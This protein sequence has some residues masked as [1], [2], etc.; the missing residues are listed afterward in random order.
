[1]ERVAFPLLGFQFEKNGDYMGSE[2]KGY[3]AVGTKAAEEV[4]NYMGNMDMEMNPTNPEILLVIGGDHH[5]LLANREYP[6]SAMVAVTTNGSFGGT[7]NQNFSK[8]DIDYVIGSIKRGNYKIDNV[9]RVEAQYKNFKTCALNEVVV[10]Q[11]DEQ[12][13]RMRVYCDGKDLYGIEIIANGM[14]ASAPTGTSGYCHSADGEVMEQYRRKFE[15]VPLTDRYQAV[16]DT[17]FIILPTY[18]QFKGDEVI[19]GRRVPTK[20]RDYRTIKEG[21]EVVV[22]FNRD[23][24]NKIVPDSLKAYR[25][26]FD[27]KEGDQV[28]FRAAEEDAKYIRIL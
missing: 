28:I 3:W 7:A 20:V 6:K 16:D 22:T 21:K 13:N 4:R 12:C 26:Y 9:M 17:R 2:L 10:T 23:N 8:N 25:E 5:T 11:D 1:V 24:R 19:K 14:M 15:L 27:F 18:G